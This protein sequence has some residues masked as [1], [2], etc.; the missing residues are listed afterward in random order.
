MHEFHMNLFNDSSDS[1]TEA[2]SGDLI[3]DP[4]RLR[5]RITSTSFSSL[6]PTPLLLQEDLTRGCGGQI[7]PAGNLLA[8]YVLRNYDSKTLRGKRIVELGAGGGLVGYVYP[9]HSKTR[10]RGG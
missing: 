8:K 9:L 3:P 6:L 1:E 2:F 10:E 5:A 7:W 4:P